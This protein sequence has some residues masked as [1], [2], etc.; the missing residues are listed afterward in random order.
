MGKSPDTSDVIVVGGGAIGLSIA[1]QLVREGVRVAVLERGRCGRE[2]SWAGAGILKHGNWRRT[3]PLFQLRRRSLQDYERFATELHDRT[4]IDPQYVRCG[5]LELLLDKRQHAAALAETQAAEA[6]RGEYGRPVVEVLSPEQARRCEP[7]LAA[8]L[9]GLKHYPI[10]AQVRSPRL[11]QALVA[12]CRAEGVEIVEHAEVRDLIR[13]GDRVTG[14]R[15]LLG[16]H[17]CKHVV[18]AAGAWSSQ[19]DPRLEELMPVRPVRGQVVLLE[20]QPRPFACV[21]ERGKHYLVPRLDGRILVGATEEHDAGYEKR[22]TA[23]GVGDLLAF[24]RWVVPA[25]AE[26]ALVGAWCGLRPGTPDGRP[27]LGPVPGADGLLVATGHFRSGLVLAPVT[28]RI[29]TDLI[30]RGRASIPVDLGSFAPGRQADKRDHAAIMTL[31][32]T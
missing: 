19:L 31:F 29:I 26:A 14:V 21:I 18:L 23:A 8:D 30:V 10:T 25:L 16:N 20:M 12:A 11:M 4:G 2:A 28:A 6:Y 9:T 3:D 24:A 17:S 5:S 15:S 27:D 13:D 22:T 1:W 7:K 32:Q